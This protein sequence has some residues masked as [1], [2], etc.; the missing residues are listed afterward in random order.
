MCHTRE[1]AFQISKEYERFSKYLPSAKVYIWLNSISFTMFRLP[2]SLE[3][4]PSRKTKK[5]WKLTAHTSLSELLEEHWRWPD[6]ESWSST[7]LN[8]SYWTNVI[9]WSE[10]QVTIRLKWWYQSYLTDMRRDVQ[11]IV[12]MTPQEKQV[13]MFSATLPK[14]LRVVCKKFMQ[15]VRSVSLHDLCL[16]FDW[17]T[18]IRPICV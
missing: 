2:C 16:P 8:I 9:V 10:I 18:S 11:E 6:P 4:C 7:K 12:K 17:S 1:L 13:M 14:E 5:L 3:E 15:D